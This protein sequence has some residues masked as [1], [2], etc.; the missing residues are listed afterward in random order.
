MYTKVFNCTLFPFQPVTLHHFPL[1]A[2]HPYAVAR[3]HVAYL[4]YL[5]E[6]WCRFF[7]HFA[8]GKYVTHQPFQH[9]KSLFWL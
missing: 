9:Q 3:A 6:G 5:W 2:R 8:L 4:N 7:I 1:A